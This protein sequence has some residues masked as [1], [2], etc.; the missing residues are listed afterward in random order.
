MDQDLGPREFPQR[1]L[2]LLLPPEDFPGDITCF[3]Q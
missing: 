3:I 2:A 1:Q